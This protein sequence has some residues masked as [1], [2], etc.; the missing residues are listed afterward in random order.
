MAAWQTAEVDLVAAQQT[1]AVALV[2]AGRT[3]VARKSYQVVAWSD[4]MSRLVAA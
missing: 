3:A 2:I 1:A 4:E